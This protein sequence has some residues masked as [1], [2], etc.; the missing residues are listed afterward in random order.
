MNEKLVQDVN[1]VNDIYRDSTV[2]RERNKWGE[3]LL[4]FGIR[5]CS[6]HTWYGVCL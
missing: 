2:A 6:L 5:V 4:Y 1:I 3:S